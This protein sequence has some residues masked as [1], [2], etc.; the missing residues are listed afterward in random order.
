MKGG[1]QKTALYP[2]RVNAILMIQTLRNGERRT[3][4]IGEHKIERYKGFEIDKTMVAPKVS[5]FFEG[6]EY[7]FK[8]VKE[9]KAFI[10][11]LVAAG[12]RP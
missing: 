8:T 10:D 3:E 6:D 2:A 11:E 9:A 4:V 7:V 1:K 12:K 5:V